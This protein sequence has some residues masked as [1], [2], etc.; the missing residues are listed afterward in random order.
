LGR[1][2]EK[3]DVN[4]PELVR[5]SEAHGTMFQLLTKRGMV[6][7]A[8]LDELEKWLELAQV[9]W[10]KMELSMTPK[11]HMLLNHLVQLL[12]KTG[13]G[14]VELGEDHIERAHQWR[15]RDR[16][17]YSRLRCISRMASCKAKIQNLRLMAPIKKV[18]AEVIQS[19]KQNLARCLIKEGAAVAKVE[20][21]EVQEMIVEEDGEEP[22]EPLLNPRKKM[23]K[24][25]KYSNTN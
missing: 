18:Q 17:R 14:L 15:E 10:A 9:K 1:R 7:R 16:Q 11:W 12:E 21:A 23:K 13:G 22:R 6:T 19:S 24:E 25:L 5:H 3:I 8:V 2:E 4:I 20:R